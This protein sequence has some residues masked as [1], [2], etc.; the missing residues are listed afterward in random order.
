[1]ISFNLLAPSNYQKTTIE[2]GTLGIIGLVIFITVLILCTI[3]IY[4]HFT[5][6]TEEDK[7]EQAKSA[8][9]EKMYC[10]Q[11]GKKLSKNSTYC[12]YCGTK[13]E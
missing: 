5:W 10:K 11:C 1:M 3:F 2:C 7:K 8:R 4:I 6:E 12:S 13:Q 9:K